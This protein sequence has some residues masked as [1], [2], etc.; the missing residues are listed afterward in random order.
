VSKLSTLEKEKEEERKCTA[1]KGAC[2]LP[3]GGKEVPCRWCLGTG[4]WTANPPLFC[5]IMSIIPGM[6]GPGFWLIP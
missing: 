4:E 5:Q 2:V 1:C 6:G 3:D